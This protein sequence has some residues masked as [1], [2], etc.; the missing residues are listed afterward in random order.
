MPTLDFTNIG[1]VLKSECSRSTITAID[2]ATDTCTLSN[3]ETALI[4]YH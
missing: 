3:G 4:F 1:D 2:S